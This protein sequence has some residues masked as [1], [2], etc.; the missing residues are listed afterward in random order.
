VCWKS[1]SSCWILHL[2]R[3][4]FLSAPIPSPPLWFAV[5]VLHM[6]ARCSHLET[7]G[8]ARGSAVAHHV[9]CRKTLGS[10]ASIHR[11]TSHKDGELGSMNGPE[12]P[13]STQAGQDPR[14]RASTS[15]VHHRKA[16][17]GEG[18]EKMAAGCSRQVGGVVVAG[19]G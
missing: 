4:E 5:S 13:T 8:A 17:K 11:G 10:T 16:S 12:A 6:A 9:P 3:E 14:R 15:L 7:R 2:L 1:S 19:S 18:K